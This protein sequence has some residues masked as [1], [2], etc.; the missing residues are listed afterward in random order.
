[1][2]QGDEVARSLV[3]LGQRG[4][5]VGLRHFVADVLEDPPQTRLAV[6]FAIDVSVLGHG[7]T[8][9]LVKRRTDGPQLLFAGKAPGRGGAGSPGRGSGGSPGGGMGSPGGP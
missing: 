7:I 3:Q 6:D 4:A 1:M 9:S 5:P 8:S 2:R